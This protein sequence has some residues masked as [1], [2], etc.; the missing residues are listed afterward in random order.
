LSQGLQWN[1]D[2]FATNGQ[3]SVESSYVDPFVTWASDNGLEGADA[4][5]SADPDG[6]GVNNLLEFATNSDPKNGGSKA[7]VYGKIHMIGGN[8]VLTYTVATR[9]AATFAANGSK[10]EATKDEVKYTIEGSDDLTTW[11]TVAVT[12]VVGADATAVQG[13]IEPV[14]PTLQSGWE[15]HTFRT[16]GNASSDASDYIR[17]K[18]TEVAPQ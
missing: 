10:Q 4:A 18:V 7:R 3:I 14:L 15:W 17:L 8:P 6:D 2:S 1:T 9:A 13:A 5:K 16:D 12:E 11:N